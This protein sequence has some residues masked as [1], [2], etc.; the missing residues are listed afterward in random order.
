V[1][2]SKVFEIFSNC[3]FLG[4]GVDPRRYRMYCI[5]FACHTRSKKL[6]YT[7]F[8]GGDLNNLRDIQ[9]FFVSKVGVDLRGSL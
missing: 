7:G 6:E 8:R 2:I 3:L 9:Q 5:Y 1:G 4:G